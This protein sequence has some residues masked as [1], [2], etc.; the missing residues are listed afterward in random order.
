MAIG[1]KKRAKL[2]EFKNLMTIFI[3]QGIKDLIRALLGL[4]FKR[5]L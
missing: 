4:I 2:K 5:G 1:S 3:G